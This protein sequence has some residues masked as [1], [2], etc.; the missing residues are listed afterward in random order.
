MSNLVIRAAEEQLELFDENAETWQ[1]EWRFNLDQEKPDS[2]EEI[3]GYIQF[4]GRLTMK[5]YFLPRAEEVCG[6]LGL[7]LLKVD[8]FKASADLG[9]NKYSVS[10]LV[11][12]KNANPK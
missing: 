1:A 5:D 3:R 10:A 2:A 6:D 8:E 7:T 4:G 11:T 9:R 12:L